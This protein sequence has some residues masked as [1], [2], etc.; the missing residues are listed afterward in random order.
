MQAM[1]IA[2][3]SSFIHRYV[4]RTVYSPT[5]TM[6]GYVNNS[7]AYFNVTDFPEG[8]GP[9]PSEITPEYIGTQ[10]CRSVTGLAY[11]LSVVV[12]EVNV[13]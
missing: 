10:L 6:E 3:T 4:Y 13:Y 7:L 12:L 1:I 2:F 9:H 5:G 11:L 8:F